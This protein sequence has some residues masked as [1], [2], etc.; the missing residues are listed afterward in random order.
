MQNLF[1]F[2]SKNKEIL[3]SALKG[4]TECALVNLKAQK[5]RQDVPNLDSLNR[6]PKRLQ[7]VW[8]RVEESAGSSSALL[9]RGSQVFGSAEGL[10]VCVFSIWLEQLN[11]ESKEL[12]V[13]LFN[14]LCRI[15]IMLQAPGQ[16]ARPK[17]FRQ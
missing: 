3:K 11:E 13:S 9:H 5:E 16:S 17:I 10:G 7:G 1:K 8:Q 12:D 15:R 2:L 4:G 14:H 6:V